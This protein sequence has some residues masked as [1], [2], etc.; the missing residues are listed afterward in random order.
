MTLESSLPGCVHS[1]VSAPLASACRRTAP[2]AK[3]WTNVRVRLC[4][5]SCVSTALARITASASRVSSWN[6]EAD[7]ARSPVRPAGDGGSCA[8]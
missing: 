6:Q 7:T 4:A 1:A 8:R 5:V 2:P 3:M